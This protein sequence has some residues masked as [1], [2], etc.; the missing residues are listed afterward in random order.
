[1]VCQL[2]EATPNIRV[3]NFSA[4]KISTTVS[5][6]LI[7]FILIIKQVILCF[8]ESHQIWTCRTGDEL[9][10]DQ[11]FMSQHLDFYPKTLGLRIVSTIDVRWNA[12]YAQLQ[13]GWR[14]PNS[15]SRGNR[16]FSS[17][18]EGCAERCNWTVKIP[19]VDE[20]LDPLLFW[21]GYDLPGSALEQLLPFAASIAAVPATEAICERRFKAGGAGTD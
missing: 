17:E 1:M 4:R 9:K 19:C 15:C 3:E 7:F 21:K 6:A 2:C 16:K 5:C 11:S 8:Y 18:K 10:A 20:N 14:R 12:L 13:S